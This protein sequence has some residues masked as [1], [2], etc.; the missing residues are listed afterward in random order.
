MRRVQLFALR[1][2]GNILRGQ[3]RQQIATSRAVDAVEDKRFG[4]HEAVCLKFENHFFGS[5]SPGVGRLGH[6]FRH[7]PLSM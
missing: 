1:D 6:V 3:R 5:S 7:G 2:F 4:V